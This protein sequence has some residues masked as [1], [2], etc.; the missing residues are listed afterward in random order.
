MFGWGLLGMLTTVTLVFQG[1]TI[2]TEVARAIWALVIAGFLCSGGLL[3]AAMGRP[4][5]RF[6]AA[7]L[8]LTLTALFL[9]PATWSALTTFNPSPDGALPYA[10]PNR[11]PG[12][13]PS[14]KSGDNQI[15]LNYLL[16]NTKPGTY[17]LATGRINRAA[18]YILETGRPVLIFGGY[19]GQYEV[20]TIDQIVMLV[21]NR[22]LRFVL[23]EGLDQHKALAQWVQQNCVVVDAS[24]FADTASLDP[25]IPG[26]RP[27]DFSLYDCEK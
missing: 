16:A 3:L 22:Q 14:L 12:S 9:A 15:L 20:V 11:H 1:V 6:V 23:D 4:R 21:N 8:S 19:V 24:R 13:D 27:N 2:W 26:E 7:A 10:G 18:S 17:L 5:P 25:I